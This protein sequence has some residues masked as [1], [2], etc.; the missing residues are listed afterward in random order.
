M[1]LCYTYKNKK[2]I[3]KFYSKREDYGRIKRIGTK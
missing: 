1:L 3:N 2:S